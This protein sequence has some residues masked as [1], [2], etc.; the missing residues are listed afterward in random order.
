MDNQLKP[1][2]GQAQRTPADRGE[3]SRAEFTRRILIVTGV[4][5]AAVA[6]VMLF[7]LASDIVFLFF[8]AVLLAILLRAA[9]DAL[10][11]RTGL[12]LGWSFGLVVVTLG[13]A[14]AVA[15]YAAGSMA[16]AQ[17]NHLVADLPKSTE[18]ARAYVRQY[19]WGDAAL[20]WMPAAGDLFDRSVS[21]ASRAAGFL[22]T[23]FGLFGT[24]W[25]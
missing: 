19:P 17:F 10:G 24:C 18:Q 8:A 5:V 21:P 4:A 25:C 23:T 6:A 22:S 3:D 14:F 2:A 9:G 15:A 11:R 16:V 12:G 1:Q 20:Q 7:V 13:A